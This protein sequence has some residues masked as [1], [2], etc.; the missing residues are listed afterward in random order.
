[1]I[2]IALLRGVNVGGKSIVSMAALK[3]CFEG[4]GFQN[5]TTYINSGNVIFSTEQGSSNEIASHIEAAL[6]QAFDPGIHVLVKAKKEL[7]KLVANVPEEW[8]NNT[9]TRCDVMFLWPAID[10]ERVLEELPTKPDLETV[11]Y[12][13]GAVIWHIDRPLITKSRMARIIGTPVYKQI[14][15]RNITTVRKLVALTNEID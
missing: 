5:V 6:D 12:V 15:T 13:P 11:S 7:E 14:T 4:L 9:E 1:M 8:V 3:D 2:Y 10:N